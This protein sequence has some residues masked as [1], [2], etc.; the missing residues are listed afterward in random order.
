[1]TPAVTEPE[2]RNP[3]D[4][5]GIALGVAIGVALGTA[6][7]QLALGMA[8]GTAFGAVIDVVLHTR[9]SKKRKGDS[10]C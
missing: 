4:G 10:A 8:L 9:H 1:M 2:K 7:G 3:R 5:E 6:F